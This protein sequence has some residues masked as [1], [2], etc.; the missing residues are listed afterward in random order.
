MHFAHNPFIEG[1]KHVNYQDFKVE[2]ENL[3]EQYIQIFKD[4]FAWID[5]GEFK[6]FFWDIV[7]SDDQIHPNNWKVNL[8]YLVGMIIC[9][10]VLLTRGKIISQVYELH[11]KWFDYLVMRF[12]PHINNLTN[13]FLGKIYDGVPVMELPQAK[14]LIDRMKR[15]YGTNNLIDVFTNPNVDITDKIRA[16]DENYKLHYGY[17]LTRCK[18]IG[19]E[20]NRLENQNNPKM[21]GSDLRKIFYLGK[22]HQKS[23][24]P[25][26]DDTLDELIHVRNALSH[27]E[28]GGISSIDNSKIE[29]TDQTPQG[30][31]TFNRIVEVG[32]LWKFY[33]ELIS[34]DR[35]LDMISIFLQ[36]GLQLIEEQKN[37]IVRFMCECGND[38]ITYISPEWTEIV[39]KNCLKIHR[40]SRL[41]RIP[42]RN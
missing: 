35:G 31:K 32:D 6:R 1:K 14:S 30:M 37:N 3:V 41:R 18:H 20:L 5:L 22:N 16:F 21:W 42:L 36:V 4:V 19:D 25:L 33:Y 28:S 13:D 29:I 39:C 11:I 34:L 17:F 12:S 27:V 8:S 26:I 38:S 9:Q 24:P 7:E 15:V 23:P 2:I 10:K 40:V